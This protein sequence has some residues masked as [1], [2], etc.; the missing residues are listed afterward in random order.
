MKHAS[1]RS[2]TLL[3]RVGTLVL[4]CG[5]AMSAWGQGALRGN[6]VDALPPLE[7]PPAPQGPA[8]P[9]VPNPSAAQAAIQI[10][11][12]QR[13]GPRYFDVQGVKSVDFA[14][15]QAILEPLAGKPATVAQLVQEVNRIT[16][17]YRSEGYP[18]SFALLQEQNFAD[19]L[20][21]V[22]VVE[23]HIGALRIE[24]DPGNAESRLRALAQPLIDEKPLTQ[25]LLERQL[26]LMRGV[27]GII[28][29]PALDLPRR[30]DGA[31][32][33]VLQATHKPVS[34]NG[35]IVDL[36]TGEQG[37]VNLSTNSLTPLGE[38]VKL[39]AAVPAQSGDVRY[40][41]GEAQVPIGA[42]GLAVKVDGYTYR[43]RPDEQALEYLGFNRKVRNE[44]VGVGLSYPIL[45]NNEHSLTASGGVYATQ[46]RD[47]YTRDQDNAW[48]EQDVRVRAATA[49]LQYVQVTPR[50]SRDVSASVS[51][52]FDVA[53]ADKK[54]VSNFGFDGTPDYDLEFTRF[55]LE[56]RQTVQLPAQFGVTL[57]AAG[58]YSDDI[59]PN[60]EQI[61]FGSW[62]FAMG[63][64]QGEQSG[65]KGFGAS[66]ELNRR[67]NIGHR[68]LAAVQ[69]YVLADYA[70]TWYN[71][72]NLRQFNERELSSA[73]LGLRVTDD[74]YYLFDFNAAKPMGERT[75]NGNDR[76]WRFNANYSVF[77]DAF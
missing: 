26:N 25:V 48:F 43:A 60:T 28:F 74:R 62:R 57:A 5:G 37:L 24:G 68:F 46:S 70:R 1:T 33:L 47:I 51:R 75:L 73:A 77:Y 2:S 54:L 17:L 10:R 38:Q 15:I 35:G 41:A 44:R 66:I 34:V 9:A 32:E 58:Q 29:T 23:G 21:V 55:N 49:K 31:S 53:G 40:F 13:V 4:L 67:F 61:S 72:D 52:G 30:A 71:A 65:D 64:P 76:D 7:P 12:A 36:G 56:G 45:L 50:Q 18:L 16:E 19:G 39:T 20:V 6:P 3:L 8:T 22:T 27:P 14:R 42:D 63:Y 59:L 69:P 11:L